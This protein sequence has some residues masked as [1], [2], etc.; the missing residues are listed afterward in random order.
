MNDET[1]TLLEIA[2]WFEGKDFTT[3]WTSHAFPDWRTHLAQ[4][5][6][7]DCDVLEVGSWEGRSA[8]FFLEFLPRSRVTCIDPFTGNPKRHANDPSYLDACRLVRT[9]FEKNVSGYGE[10]VETIA[11][12]S[13]PSLDRLARDER[14]FDVC[15]IDGSHETDDVLVDSLL[16]WRML[17]PGGI[18]IWDDYG[19]PGE[20]QPG[21]AIDSF[22]AMR[23]VEVELLVRGYQVIIQRI[24]VD[25]MDQV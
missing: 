22:L 17:R 5:R 6:D 4:F 2:R 16:A 1:P 15:Y 24:A 10:R 3:D 7:R 21:K 8:V 18:L 12:R 13:V 9:R 20:N 25:H 23:P 19:K 14:A 11:S